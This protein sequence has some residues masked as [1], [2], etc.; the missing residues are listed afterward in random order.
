MKTWILIVI[1][2]LSGCALIPPSPPPPASPATHALWQTHQAQLRTLTAWRLNGRIA[3]TTE[4][5]NWTAHV[6]WQQQEQE[7]RLRF[8]A[9]L[10]QG[11][12]L[13]EGN[14][15]QVMMHTAEQKTYIAE[16]PDALI[17]KTLNLAIPITGLKFWIRGLPRAEPSLPAYRLYEHGYLYRL[18]QDGWQI[19][20]TRY[21]SNNTV[22]LPSKI[23]LDNGQFKVKIVISSW[24]I[25]E[26]QLSKPLQVWNERTVRT[27]KDDIN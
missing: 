2:S 11:A 10:G 13:L 15:Q 18:Q 8:N 14:E 19:E 9:P 23:F 25:R 24:D 17:L 27:P 6:H 26:S 7:Y 1:L 21:I 3:I 12:L 20:Y 16:N 5:D 4:Q 22:E